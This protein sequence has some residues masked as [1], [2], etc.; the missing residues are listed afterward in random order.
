MRVLV[1]GAS[2]FIG[3][4]AAGM[5]V[6][7]GA[8]VHAIGRRDPGI[9]GLTYHRLDLLDGADLAPLLA[10]LKATH[11]LH[12]AWVTTP[13][14]LWTTEE[15]LDWLAA[16][17]RLARAFAAAGGRRGAIAGTGAEYCWSGP[18]LDERS[19]PLLPATPYGQ[20]KAS[21][22]QVLEKFAPKL[23]LSLA[24]G[25]IF[26]PFGPREK[27]GRL[28]PDTIL[29]LL[30]G[31]SVELTDGL[32]RLDFMHVDD[33]AAGLVEL[34]LSDVEGAVNV[35]SGTARSVRSVV[36]D[37]AARTGGRE[38]LRFGVRA[39]DP[40]E[41]P[42]VGPDVTRLREEVGFAPRYGW[43]EAVDR[44]VDWWRAAMVSRS[45]RA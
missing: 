33:V 28:L 20:A 13:R 42:V 14:L 10:R 41:A 6:G 44:T 21:L 32:Q 34:L 37:F 31:R 40:W 43:D 4:P 9:A 29:A 1:T 8:E 35:A 19:T 3:R 11:L 5:L 30:E 7:S 45:A 17:V 27:P 23:G 24:W 22:F 16:S 26:V 2:G 15:N 39:R 25:R 36:E 18:V 12:L 38:L